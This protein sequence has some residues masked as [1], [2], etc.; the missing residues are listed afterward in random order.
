VSKTITDEEYQ[1]M[2]DR[3][4]LLGCYLQTRVCPKCKRQRVQGYICEFC[5]DV[6]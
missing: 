3:S 4:H 5:G 2:S 6:N 1:Y